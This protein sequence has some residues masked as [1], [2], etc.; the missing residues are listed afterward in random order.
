[1]GISPSGRV[2]LLFFFFFLS[3]FEVVFYLRGCIPSI[4]EYLAVRYTRDV[5]EYILCYKEDKGGRQGG[6]GG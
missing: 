6:S 3:I 2:R 4:L 1:M 5:F